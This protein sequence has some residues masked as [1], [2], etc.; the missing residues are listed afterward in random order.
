MSQKM[1]GTIALTI[2]DDILG[3]DNGEFESLI[4]NR[5]FGSD[6]TDSGYYIEY[7]ISGVD[8][9]FSVTLNVTATP[10]VDA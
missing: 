2:P 3:L 6:L 10:D 1:S 7:R 4:T 5:A 8:S 9:E